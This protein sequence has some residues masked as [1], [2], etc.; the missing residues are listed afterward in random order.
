MGDLHAIFDTLPDRAEETVISELARIL[1]NDTSSTKLTIACG[2]LT[3]RLF[4]QKM[5]GGMTATDAR[6]H[7]EDRWGFGQGRQDA[8]LLRTAAKSLPTRL[9]NTTEAKLLLDTVAEAYAAEVGLN[10]HPCLDIPV[11]A[12][13]P[14]ITKIQNGQLS[15]EYPQVAVAR[16]S[17]LE[18]AGP[19]RIDETMEAQSIASQARTESD[20]LR[21]R[22]DILTAELGDEFIEGISP[23]WSPMKIRKYESCWN[24]VLQD[25]LQ[26]V[27]SVLRGER[28]VDNAGSRQVCD[29]IVRRSDQRLLDVMRFLANDKTW[30]ADELLIST[31]KGLMVMLI[32]DSQS[33][34]FRSQ[35]SRFFE[36]G[37]S[38]CSTPPTL[39]YNQTILVSDYH[40][41][42]YNHCIRVSTKV[43]GV[44]RINNPLTDMYQSG[45]ASLQRY[46]LR[47]K[48]KT[49]LLTGAGTSSIGRALLIRLLIAGARVLVT[50]SRFSPTTCQ[51]FQKVY[52]QYG[53]SGSQ[54]IVAPFNQGSKGDCENL[55]KYIFDARGGLGW[56]L[57][58]VIPFAALSQEGQIDNLGS[59]PELAHRIMLTN[60]LRLLGTIR[61]YKQA[62]PINP[63]P[64]RAILPLS[65]NHGI[66]GNDGLY[67]ESKA[68][69]EMLLNKWHSEQW[70][71]YISI[72]GAVIGWVRGTGLMAANDVVA[73]EVEARA[74]IRTFSQSEMAEYLIALF[75]EPLG[76]Q[77]EEQPMRVDLSGDMAQAPNIH[78]I[79]ATIRG[80]M[81][82]DNKMPDFQQRPEAGDKADYGANAEHGLIT[83][84]ANLKLHFP[85]L[86]D[87]DEEIEPL[88]H[89]RG[90]ADLDRVAV[91]TG[92]S[93]VGPWGN[94][95]TRWEMEAHGMFSLEGCIEMAWMMGLI[96]HHN[97]RLDGDRMR[98]HY[99]GWIDVKS[100]AP[101]ADAEVKALYERQILEHA[102]I[103]VVEPELD[104]G[105]D[106]S[107]KQF[108]HEVVLTN[109]LPPFKAPAELA[110]Q[111]SLEHGEMVDVVPGPSDEAEWTVRLR[112]GATIL[113]PKA[114]RFDRAVAGQIPQGWDARRY[115][116]PDW[117]AEQIGRETLFAI[118]STAEALLFSGIVD[119]Y[120]LYQYMHVS[121]V[122]N[123][124]GSGQGG[125]Q[126]M[127]KI[128]RHRYLDKSVQSDAL[129][130][131]F[132]NTTAA[133]IN[134]LLL[135][136][137]GP[138]RT[139]VGA[140]ATSIESLESGYELITSGKAKVVLV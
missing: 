41:S 70:S 118:V 133:W 80:E 33:W 95:R 111:F 63:N 16:S 68:G 132:L 138:I 127:K 18:E 9:K 94:A 90:M 129:Q 32:E 91:I 101:V 102:G 107:R 8:I 40:N 117:A 26:L 77:N 87:Y 19:S 76:L 116:V 75:A 66:I 98:E 99:I 31:V 92:M 72:C 46:G 36:G 126:A 78:S 59:K 57:D 17:H 55:V 137:S 131:T 130:E 86:P 4:S 52:K 60:V 64:T 85:K 6:K 1:T 71:S 121:E 56:D 11:P 128:F 24:W 34:L 136:S 140:C 21:R 122:G 44:W 2:K 37:S 93:E 67:S 38:S 62:G 29:M 79:L 58:Y 10:L 25:L 84:M 14:S 54:L 27:N 73:S 135:S 42:Q 108:L 5:P 106:P 105:Y 47:L 69:L 30:N 89:L 23:M 7:L 124:V 61:S 51:E 110:K 114:L 43:D 103:R 134:M 119:P 115:G 74:G 49:V 104:E 12:A 123:C 50:T 82:R 112:R 15:P 83:P 96:T 45:L 88:H 39:N 139:P 53:S 100:K 125:L 3:A 97:G 28:H 22:L 109:D 20:T 48:G 35:T 113:V 81:V 120:E 13:T 65:P